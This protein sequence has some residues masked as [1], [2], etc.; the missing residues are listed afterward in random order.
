MAIKLK[1]QNLYVKDATFFWSAVHQPKPNFAK[2]ANVYEITTIVSAEDAKELKKLKIAKE[3]KEIGVDVD[4]DLQLYAEYEGCYIMK[5]SC[6]EFTAKGKK[7]TISVVDTEGNP[8]TE[9]LGNGTKGHLRFFTW[10]GDKGV[11]KG[12]L[13]SRINYVVVTDLIPY[14]DTGSGGYDEEFGVTLKTKKSAV[15]D[16]EE[17]FDDDIPY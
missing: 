11:N 10:V 2:D 16:F 13:N 15:D 5:A 3:L 9:N 8:I 12:K 1:E 7:L 4:P 14:S 17:S 6:P